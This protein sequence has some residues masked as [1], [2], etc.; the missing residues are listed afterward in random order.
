ML[1]WRRCFALRS[2]REALRVAHASRACCVVVAAAPSTTAP[3][4]SEQEEGRS[5]AVGVAA[6]GPVVPVR[7]LLLHAGA[8]A[9]RLAHAQFRFCFGDASEKTRAAKLFMATCLKQLNAVA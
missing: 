3:S 9:F 5:A 1:R 8:T 4:A 2:A 6:A 7:V